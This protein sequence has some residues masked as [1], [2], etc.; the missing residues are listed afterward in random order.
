MSRPQ[1]G[2]FVPLLYSSSSQLVSSRS[3]LSVEK[4]YLDDHTEKRHL[5]TR[6]KSRSWTLEC[7]TETITS[8]F[9]FGRLSPG[10]AALCFMDFERPDRPFSEK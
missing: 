9:G 1:E 6:Y 10:S 5:H 7:C 3:G 4:V 8:S 2:S